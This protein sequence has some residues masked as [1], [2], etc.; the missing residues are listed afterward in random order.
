MAGEDTNEK[1]TPM[2]QDQSRVNDNLPKHMGDTNS[3]SVI[4]L[5]GSTNGIMTPVITEDEVAQPELPSWFKSCIKTFEE[6]AEDDIPLIINDTSSNQPPETE[7]P[8]HYVINSVLYESLFDIVFPRDT[9]EQQDHS[10]MEPPRKFRHD[11]MA[12]RMPHASHGQRFLNLVVQHFARDIGA[13][14]ITLGSHDFENLATHFATLSGHSL[15]EGISAFGDLY[16]VEPGKPSE[17]PKP[18]VKLDDLIFGPEKPKPKPKPTESESDK[19]GEPKPEQEA[20]KKLPFPFARLFTSTSD[21][22]GSSQGAIPEKQEHPIIILLPE[23]ANSFYN[24]PRN[25]L[26]HLRDAVKEARSQGKEIA[27]IAIDNQNDLSYGNYWSSSPSDDDGFLSDIGSNPVKV[28]QLIVPIKTDSQK[29]LLKQDH[30]KMARIVNIRT[31][32]KRIQGGQKI[33]SFSGL[34]EPHVDWRLSEESFAAKRLNDPGFKNREIDL[35]ANALGADL[36][37]ESV[38][39]AFARLK[40]LSEWTQEKEKTPPPGQWDSVHEDARKAIKLIKCNSN[41]YKYEGKLVESIVKSGEF[42]C[43]LATEPCC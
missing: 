6:L 2:A 20:R 30:K 14:I 16:F 31:L 27:V 17:T 35:I 41:K 8:E 22:R 13:D 1:N 21:K 4:T 12:L 24:P 9:K 11:A 36:D 32:Q 18:S 3:E 25:I 34:L 39:K 23:V 15:P 33:W 38:E 29:E 40:V 43:Y 7:K 5:S 26:T 42:T 10:D 19:P 28:V 37:I